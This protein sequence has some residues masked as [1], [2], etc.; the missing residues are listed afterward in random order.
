MKVIY[1]Y[2]YL[3]RHQ[4]CNTNSANISNIFEVFKPLLTG[5]LSFSETTKDRCCFTFQSKSFGSNDACS[6]SFIN[7]E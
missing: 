5:I 6:Y 4:V 3:N 1:N 7:Q 2:Y